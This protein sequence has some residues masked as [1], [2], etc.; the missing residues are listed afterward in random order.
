MFVHSLFCF[1]PI[2]VFFFGFSFHFILQCCVC[3]PLVLC[4]YAWCA[5]AAASNRAAWWLCVLW[6]MLCCRHR[7]IFHFGFP[8]GSC[9]RL[10][11]S[12][13]FT[14]FILSLANA[15][16]HVWPNVLEEDDVS[17]Y[18]FFFFNVLGSSGSY[19][20]FWWCVSLVL[21]LLCCFLFLLF[22]LFISI[23]CKHH[24]RCVRTPSSHNRREK[25]GRYEFECVR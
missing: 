19:G 25:N 8:F 17:T 24:N 9:R 11:D 22:V 4:Y 21:F 6:P 13:L 3:S 23:Q 2:S 15:A 12:V 7:V 14:R 10:L 16:L 18:N 1:V 20:V 5:T